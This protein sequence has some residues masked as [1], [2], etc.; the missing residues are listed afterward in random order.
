MKLKAGDVTLLEVLSSQRQR[1][2]HAANPVSEWLWRG[3]GIERG[4]WGREHGQLS[5]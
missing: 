5:R 4:G 2:R 3:R 1:R